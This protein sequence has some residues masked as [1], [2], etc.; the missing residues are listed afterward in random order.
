MSVAENQ[1]SPSPTPPAD[2]V[3]PHAARP[4]LRLTEPAG[5]LVAAGIFLVVLMGGLDSFVVSTALPTIATDLHQV[6]GVAFVVSAYLVSATIAVPVFGRLSDIASRRNVFLAGTVIFIGGSVLAGFSQSLTE[7]IIFR[8]LQGFGG[9]AT[10]PVAI[11]MIAALF[12]PEDRARAIGI[13]GA[14]AGISIVAGPLLGSFIVSVTTW[15]WVFYINLPFGLFAALILV[16]WVDPLRS[17]TRGRFDLPGAA[18]ISGWVSALMVALFG[19]SDFGWAWTDYRVIG[20]LSTTVV[21]LSAFLWWELRCTQPL[22]P[23]RLLGRRAILS[24]NG[25]LLFTGLLLSAV[26]TFLSLFVGVALGGSASDIRDMIYF[27]AIPMIV[28]ANVSG[29]LLNRCS[30]RTLLVPALLISGVAGLSLSLMSAS[31][32]LWELSFGI[33]PIGGVALPLIPLGFG[34]GIALAGATIAI[35]NEAPP[36]Q[37]GAAVGLTKFFQTLGGALGVSLLTVFQSWR[38]HSLSLGA[39]SS[40]ALR[41]ALVTSYDEVFLILGVSVLLAL[42]CSFWLSGRVLAGRTEKRPDAPTAVESPA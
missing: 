40:G 7:L 27:F 38:F 13:L 33:L 14:T 34:L 28:G 6:N 17:A 18:L 31:T 20:L 10:F 15:R 26:I 8:G 22:L 36:N 12:G 2:D 19:V 16:L 35:Q 39:E 21:L 23:L 1:S 29:V 30:Y 32:P 41:D 5:F 9:G 24:A 11:A 37:V 4:W 3:E 42:V 25:I